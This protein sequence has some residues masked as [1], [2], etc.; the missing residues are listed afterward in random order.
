MQLESK[1]FLVQNLVKNHRETLFKKEV[2]VAEVVEGFWGGE[3][4]KKNCE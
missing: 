3:V 2:S 1:E 4:L